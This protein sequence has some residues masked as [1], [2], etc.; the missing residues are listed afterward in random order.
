MPDGKAQKPAD[1]P[2]GMSGKSSEVI[3]TDAE[4]RLILA[5]ALH[6]ARTQG[7][8][9][10]V[11]AATLTGAISVALGKVYVGVFSNDDALRDRFLSSTRVAGE[12]MWPIPLDRHYKEQIP[13][14]VGAFLNTGRG[15]CG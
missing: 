2:I 4:G 5:D 10:L 8:T 13:R 14:T 7:C 3:N 15:F 1:G 11:D 6:Y 12:K 9:H